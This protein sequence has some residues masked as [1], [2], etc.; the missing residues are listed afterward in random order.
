MVT[1][2][3]PAGPVVLNVNDSASARYL[4]SR[5]LKRAGYQV[6]EAAD[7]TEALARQF[8]GERR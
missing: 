7:G 5:I 6:V 3:L 4:V 2:T 1:A 8:T